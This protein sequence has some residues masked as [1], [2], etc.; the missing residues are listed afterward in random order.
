MRRIYA[1]RREVLAR[2]ITRELGSSCTIVGGEAGM[3]LTLLIDANIQDRDIAGKGAER[4]FWLWPLSMTYEGSTSRQGFI[5]GYGNTRTA[6][7]PN[8][9]RVLKRLLNTRLSSGNL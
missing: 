2:E 4:K 9:V 8:A 5:L 6:D 3:Q 7:I 1:E